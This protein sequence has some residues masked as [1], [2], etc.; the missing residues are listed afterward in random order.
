MAVDTVEKKASVKRSGFGEKKQP[1]LIIYRLIK[2]NDKLRDA[3][4]PYP[5][6]IRF[7]NTDII[8]W[9]YKNEDG[10]TM[11]G[12]RAIRYL[13]GFGSIF[14]DEQEAGNRV[15]PDTVLNNP[16]NRFEVKD[17]QIIVRAH[18][19]TKLQFLDMCNRNADSEYRTGILEPIFVRY[20]E[21]KLIKEK[22]DKLSKQREA[23]Q[24]AFSAD[25]RQIEFHAKYLGIPM[26]DPTNNAS[27]TFEAVKTD[28]EQAALENPEHF[29]NTFDD[30]D[31]K[32]KFLIQRAIE[33]NLINLKSIAGKAIWTYTK[34]I[35]CDISAGST[36]L[37]SLF[38]F[39]QLKA[40]EGMLKKLMD[41]Y[42]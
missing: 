17:G 42:K 32:V 21:D 3:T 33:D 36:P 5:P 13:P 8:T 6:Y 39:S 37:D 24:K 40:G 22:S 38:N 12:T 19:K 26:I 14:V 34:D 18:E 29:L 1:S 9:Q 25:E 27:R 30:G 16:N 20:S 41:E 15:I 2:R 10:S 7:P 4:P 23:I 28:Y 31:L 35:I 11:T